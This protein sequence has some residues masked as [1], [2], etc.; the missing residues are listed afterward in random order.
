MEDLL[1]PE[2]KEKLRAILTYHVVPSE[3]PAS[4]VPSKAT[5]VST[6]DPGFDLHVMRR[7]GR[8]HVNGVRVI[9]A[10]IRADNGIIHVIDRVLIP[11]TR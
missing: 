11:R 7:N 1:L 6:L 3:V 8:V 9:T 10:D 4:K 5:R 2:N